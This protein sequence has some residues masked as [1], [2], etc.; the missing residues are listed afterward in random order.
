[1]RLHMS[2]MEVRRPNASGQIITAG[3]DPLVGWMNAASQVPSGVVT[4]TFDTSTGMSAAETSWSLAA[5]ARPAAS[6]SATKSRRDRS[7]FSSAMT[8]LLEISDFRFQV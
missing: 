5:A 1:M 8:A 2:I 4:E 3:C 7:F 6:D